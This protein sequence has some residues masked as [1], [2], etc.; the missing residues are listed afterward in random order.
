MIDKYLMLGPTALLFLGLLAAGGCGT[1][2]LYKPTPADTSGLSPKQARELL[3]R[4]A[5]TLT[6]CTVLPESVTYEKYKDSCRGY[7]YAD[8]PWVEAMSYRGSSMDGHEGDQTCIYDP[9]RKTRG[10]Q[11]ENHWRGKACMVFSA[12]SEAA[13]ARDFVMA[14]TVLARDGVAFQKARDE[15]FEVAVKMYREEAVKPPLPEDA[16]RYKV[17]A[18]L[19]V[20]QTRFGD[21]AALYDDALAIAP[22][23]PAGHYNRG[24]I[25]GELRDYEGAI[26]ELKRYLKVDPES[27]NARAVQLKIY[28][29]E[30]LVPQAAK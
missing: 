14:W 6:L 9:A 30:A 15:A 13:A 2:T 24:L 11:K 1:V 25:L 3:I 8:V 22:W 4:S 29:W 19:A 7:R 17:Q 27:A 16:V 26:V 23:W 18:E 20:K 12:R 10:V 5:K 21:A 28:E